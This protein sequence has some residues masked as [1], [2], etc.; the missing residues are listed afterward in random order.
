MH[1]SAKHR[2]TSGAVTRH[3]RPTPT[4]PREAVHAGE[5]VGADIV[6]E[7]GRVEEMASIVCKKAACG[8]MVSE[9]WGEPS[10]SA[11]NR[12][13][14]GS[15]AMALLHV[16]PAAPRMEPRA[17]LQVFLRLRRIGRRTVGPWSAGH[18]TSVTK[19]H[20]GCVGEGGVQHV[21]AWWVWG[22]GP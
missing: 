16:A 15:Q 20:G 2:K 13:R 5:A 6:I 11:R 3:R 10:R 7:A 18:S 22:V 8:C 19:L 4:G 12:D 17:R 21:T 14:E 9:R 1:G